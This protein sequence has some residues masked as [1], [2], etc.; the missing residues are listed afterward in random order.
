MRPEQEV[1]TYDMSYVLIQ[2]PYVLGINQENLP[3][4]L[5]REMKEEIFKSIS[6]EDD[7]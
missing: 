3:K 1:L 2:T 4:L 7:L 6:L 5:G